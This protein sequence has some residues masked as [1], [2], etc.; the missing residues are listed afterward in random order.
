MSTT[1]KAETRREPCRPSRPAP[2]GPG[3]PGVHARLVGRPPCRVLR[4]PGLPG[5]RRPEPGGLHPSVPALRALRR[6]PPDQGARPGR[7]RRLV[8]R[9]RA[10]A[11]GAASACGERAPDGGAGPSFDMLAA[12]ERVLASICEAV[13]GAAYL[14]VRHR[15]RGAH[16]GGRLRRGHRGRAGEPGRPQVGAPGAPGPAGR[17]GRPTGSW[18]RTARRTTRRFVAVAESGGRELG[19]GDGP[20]Q[21]GRRAGS[22]AAGPGEPRGTI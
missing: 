20:H 1:P 15:P 5:G 2:R 13:I 16:R 3:A 4:A 9:G 14:A 21:E 11:R 7:Q 8:R 18:T 6:R 10:G 17:A 19:R 22:G 12:S